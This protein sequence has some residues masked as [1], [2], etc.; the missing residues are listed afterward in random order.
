MAGVPS[1]NTQLWQ[2]ILFFPCHVWPRKL[3]AGGMWTRRSSAQSPITSSLYPSRV[4][5]F[6]AQSRLRC[7]KFIISYFC[8][9]L[10]L[11]DLSFSTQFLS[12]QPTQLI[13]V[14]YFSQF[15]L[16]HPQFCWLLST[17]ERQNSWRN[18]RAVENFLKCFELTQ[19]EESI[20]RKTGKGE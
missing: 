3:E 19:P 2:T 12:V 7:R 13:P 9:I 8:G 16:L 1:W 20:Q 15:S 4:S 11:T 14:L 10:S 18:S 5:L 17:Q 6:T